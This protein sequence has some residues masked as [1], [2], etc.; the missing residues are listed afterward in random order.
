MNQYK[1]I[2]SLSQALSAKEIS[3]VEL[4]T[5]YLDR[6]DQHNE[7]I[8][9]YTH[10][11]HEKTLTYA[12]QADQIIANGD[13]RAL[14]GIPVGM[15]DLFVTKDMPTTCAS[16]MLEGYM[17][18]FNATLVQRFMDAG[19][20]V[21]G[22]NNMDEFAMGSSNETS[23]YGNCTNPWDTAYV[24]GG[25]SGGS[26]ACVAA[27][28]AIASIGTDTGGSIRQPASFCGITGIKPTYG[29][30]S[31][32]GMVAF[33]SSLDQAGPLAHSAEDCAILLN[34]LSGFD[35]NDLT[36]SRME[37]PDFTMNLNQSIDGLVIGLP[38]EYFSDQLDP[39]CAK[40]IDD[41]KN[42]LQKLGVRFKS[43]HLEN[44]KYAVATYYI[45]A[46]S[47]ASSNLSR[48]DGVRYGHRS[49]QADTLQELYINSRTEGFGDEVKRRIMIGTFALS[50]GYYDDYYQKAQKIR[51]VIRNDYLKA[52]R[53]VDLILCPTTP[54][55]AFKIGECIDDP[56]A[57]YLADIFTITAN[58]A[59]LPAMSMPAGFVNEMPFGIQ[60]IGDRFC[61]SQILQVAHQFQKV[62]DWHQRRPQHLGGKS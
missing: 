26:A 5:Y 20:V 2:A 17:S 6:I 30:I 34:T 33:A 14:T 56:I 22:K 62:T 58:L 24:P 60:L 49:E 1:T 27:D 43:I 18:P 32:Y 11:N 9:A 29:R 12:Q 31:R 19:G 38:E 28:L 54:S 15:K 16:K 57:M 52:F 13:A 40:L 45:I 47:E 23:Y 21:M 51:Q 61:E 36:S 59:G 53:D 4:A 50:S 37:V 46:P 39:D 35:P 10:V 44:L 3:A 8:N 55:T 41:A 7:K 25:S 42:E 48:F